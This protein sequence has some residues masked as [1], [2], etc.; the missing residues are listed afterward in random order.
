MQFSAFKTIMAPLE[1]TTILSA[2]RVVSMQVLLLF[3]QIQW[4]GISNFWVFVEDEN[5]R[6]VQEKNPFSESEQLTPPTYRFQ[7]ISAQVT[8]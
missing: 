6:T 7:N 3:V 5:R 1:K 2:L 8:D 4:I